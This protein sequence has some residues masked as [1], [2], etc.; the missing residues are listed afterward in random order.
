MKILLQA[1]TGSTHPYVQYGK[2]TMAT[3]NFA[4]AVLT[5]RLKEIYGVADTLPNIEVDTCSPNLMPGQVT[6]LSSS[7]S[8]STMVNLQ[9][10]PIPPTEDQ[11]LEF[12]KKDG[13]LSKMRNHRGNIPILPQTKLCP[14]CP[15]K[16]TRTTHL[17]RHLRTRKLRH[18]YQGPLLNDTLDTNERLHRCDVSLRPG[19]YRLLG[20]NEVR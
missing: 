18:L 6:L 2:P 12:R 19:S 10:V 4:E 11:P 16:F 3:Y 17:N 1:L 20:I 13:S 9:R 7:I 8:A 15:A 5:A 14:H